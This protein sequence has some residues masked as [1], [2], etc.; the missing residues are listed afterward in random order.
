MRPKVLIIGVSG[1]L[2][3]SLALH[4]RKKFLVAG[5]CFRNHVLI[6]DV[7]VFPLVYKSPEVLEMLVRIQQPDFIICAAGMNDR[8][9]VL[10]HTKA[11][12]LINVLLPVSLSILASRL[13]AQYLYL[14]CAEVFEGGKGNYSEEDNDFTL[15]DAVGKQKITAHSYIRAQT[16]E[17]TTLRIGRVLG[18][19]QPYRMSFFDRIRFA[20]S[21]K[22]PYEASKKKIRSYVSAGSVA[23]A[24]E[25]VLL[26]EF[27]AKHRVFHVG[28]ANMP[29][30]ELVESWYRLMNADPKLV[31]VLEDLRRDLSLDCTLMKTQFPGWR[32]ETK[33]Q[34]LMN[35]LSELTPASGAK[36]WQRTLQIP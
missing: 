21:S 26:G 8:K 7:Q 2:G 23:S 19:G 12:D 4:L 3:Y 33:S 30:H 20:A 11:A 29:E 18:I 13:K 25:N 35:M 22:K 24:V 16:L 1:L 31:G 34:L 10:E 6:P 14:S 36:K 17:S 27:P 5:V 32:E 15:S 28:G 9:E